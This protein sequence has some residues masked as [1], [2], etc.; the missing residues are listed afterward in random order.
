MLIAFV[1][2]MYYLFYTLSIGLGLAKV[3]KGCT[4]STRLDSSALEVKEVNVLLIP[5]QSH[6]NFEDHLGDEFAASL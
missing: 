1:I 5:P 4:T 6:E 2:K 3:V